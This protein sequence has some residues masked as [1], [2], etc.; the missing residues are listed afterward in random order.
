MSYPW[1]PALSEGF[2]NEKKFVK[3]LRN[4]L[5]RYGWVVELEVTSKSGSSRA[6]MIITHDRWGRFGVECK[7]GDR[8]RKCGNAIKQI[9]QYRDE[10]FGKPI[11]AWVACLC[12]TEYYVDCEDDHSR[13]KKN[14]ETG[15][16]RE[17][18]NTLNIGI[19]RLDTR[20]EIVFNNSN[21]MVKIPVAEI[22][23]NRNE[24]MAP[25]LE[26]LQ[27]CSSHPVKEYI[28]KL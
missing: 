14:F 11:D 12:P 23:Y 27:R 5:E 10:E 18:L 9:R 22:H 4:T 20:L 17:L 25:G 13:K 26:R 19:I 21:P 8:P 28:G 6:D 3:W 16:Y 15:Y 7:H 1:P 24:L 2:D